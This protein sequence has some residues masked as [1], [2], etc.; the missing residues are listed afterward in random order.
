MKPIRMLVML[1]LALAMVAIPVATVGAQDATPAGSPGPECV[2]PA[3]SGDMSTADMATPEPGSMD[4]ETAAPPVAEGPASRNLAQM[5][6]DALNNLLACFDSGDYEGAAALLTPNML[7]FVSGS[8]DPGDTVAAFQAQ[9]PAPMMIANIGPATIDTNNRVGLP[10]VF[11]GFFNSPGMQSAEKWYF[12]KDG[13][14]WKLDEVAPTTIPADLYPDA[15]VVN[16][17]MVD[18]AF[19]LDQ[20]T[21]P[22]GPV[23]FHV[24]N[25]S[26][27]GQP[28]VAAMVTL[29]SDI[30]TEEIIQASVLPEDQVT[31]FVGSVFLLPGQSGDIYLEDLAPGEYTIVCDVTTPDGVPHWQL[32]MVAHFTVE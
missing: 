8:A 12:V 18:Y 16:V 5:G 13:D 29:S 25:T 7:M 4:M 14:F 20:N 24:T 27:S 17:Q 10:L 30:S 3:L 11:G 21:I 28:H 22:A 1:G 31:G 23:I 32:G 2:A 9:P 15:T 19:A 26:Y 6:E